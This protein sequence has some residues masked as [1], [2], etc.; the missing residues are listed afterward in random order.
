MLLNLAPV[1]A[2]TAFHRDAPPDARWPWLLALVAA[3]LL[4][5]VPLTALPDERPLRLGAGHRRAVL[6]PGRSRLPGARAKGMV[7]AGRW[8]G[9]V[10]ADPDA[11]GR[12]KPGPTGFISLTDYLHDPHQIRVS[13][14]ELLILLL[15]VALIVPD[16]IRAQAATHTPPR[17]HP[18]Y[19]R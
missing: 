18:G 7:P 9:R 3:Y 6:R 15:A 17:P 2:M 8:L 16:A 13:L 4:V 1:L 11:A 12:R 19:P 14:A 5:A 10:V